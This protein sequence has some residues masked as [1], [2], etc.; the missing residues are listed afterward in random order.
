MT[1]VRA[2]LLD[3]DGTLVE[4]V[5][6]NGDPDL[7]R[8]MPG[9]AE[10]MALLRSRG[11]PA[12]VVTNQSGIARGLIGWDDMG[13]VHARIDEL[14]GPFHAWAVC[15]HGPDDGCACRKP[16]PALLLDSARRLGAAPAECV[17]IGDIGSDVEAARAAGARA[18]LVPTPVTLAEEVREAPAVA[19]DLL[20]AVRAALDGPWPGPAGGRAGDGRAPVREFAPADRAARTPATSRAAA[21]TASR[22]AARTSARAAARTATVRRP[23]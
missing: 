9:A 5:P 3:R 23:S 12:A 17:V 1:A 19:P 22:T 20:T 13:R 2:V 18:I 11:V 10:A 7:V 15:P 21:R 16:A 8:P 4:D 14:L 6:Y